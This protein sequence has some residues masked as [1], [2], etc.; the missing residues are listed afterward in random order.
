M[1][2]RFLVSTDY[3]PDPYVE[4]L[5]KILLEA[6]FNISILLEILLNNE[7]NEY[8]TDLAVWDLLMTLL[9]MPEIGQPSVRLY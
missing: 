9:P 4:R 6:K 8:S 3:G 5:E 1:A 7:Y 2:W